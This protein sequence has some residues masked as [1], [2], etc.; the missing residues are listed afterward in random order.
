MLVAVDSP[1]FLENL[2]FGP[3]FIAGSLESAN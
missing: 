1:K 3:Y 2:L